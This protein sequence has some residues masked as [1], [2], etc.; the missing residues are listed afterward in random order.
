MNVLKFKLLPFYRALYS[1]GNAIAFSTVTSSS[2]TNE[3]TG[4]EV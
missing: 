1:G 4:S 2:N 3:N